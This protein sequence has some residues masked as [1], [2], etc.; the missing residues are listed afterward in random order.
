ML[1]APGGRSPDR[2]G[3]CSIVILWPCRCWPLI[4]AP[5]LD[6]APC[7]G[8]LAPDGTNYPASEQ[9]HIGDT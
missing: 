4:S 1:P 3:D 6:I 9:S 7:G 2:G 5:P 8:L